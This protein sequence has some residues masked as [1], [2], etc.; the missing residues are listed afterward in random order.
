M[1]NRTS[2]RPWFTVLAVLAS[3]AGKVQPLG[4][5]EGKDGVGGGI[6]DEGGSYAGSKDASGGAS[7][8]TVMPQ[9]GTTLLPQSTDPYSQ[10]SCYSACAEEILRAPTGCKLCHGTA[11]KVDGDLDLESL[12][13]IK[14][15]KD[16]PAEHAAVYAGSDCPQGDKLIDSVNVNQSWLLKKI[17][18]QQGNCGTQDP[19]TAPLNQADMAC[20]TTYI[21][22]IAGLDEVR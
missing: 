13:R 5:I 10:E 6:I 18:G 14:R 2:V 16:V 3:C 15:L 1:I 11:I 12:G 9:G 22:C 4:D 17:R 21:E 19:P 7:A 20:L 8:S